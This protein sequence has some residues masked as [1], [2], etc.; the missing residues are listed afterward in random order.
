VTEAASAFGDLLREFR[1]RAGL[2]QSELA[3]KA[4][5]SEDAVGSLERGVR[6]APYRSTVALLGKALEL[7]AKESSEL[8]AARVAARARSACDVVTHNIR[9]ERTP[10]VGRESDVEHVLKLL[11]RSRL[12]SVTGS[13]GVGKTRVALETGRRLLK[14]SYPEVWFIDLGQLID[15]DFIAAKIAA[16]VRLSERNDTMTAL[17]SA[18]SKRHALLILDNCEH[19]L[20]QA[21]RAADAILESCPRVA[22]LATSREP[23]NVAGEFVYRLPSLLLEPA[24]ELFTQRAQAADPGYPVDEKSRALIKDLVQHLGGIPLVLELTAAQVPLLGLDVLRARKYEYLRVPSSR[25][26]LP[27]RQQTVLATIEWSYDL[28]TEPER[29][30]LRDVSIFVGGFTLAAAETVCS[31]AAV[32][33]SVVLPLLSALANKSLLTVEKVDDGVRY[34]LLEPVRGYAFEK[35]CETNGDDTIARRHAQWLATI[36]DE[37]ENDTVS[38]DR[39]AEM[40]PEF[41]NVRTAVAWSLN[42]EGPEDRALAGH[43]LTGLFGL[44]DR[45]GR[46]HEHRQWVETA[47]ARIDEERHPVV[48]AN[49]LR[50][51]MLRTQPER[52]ALDPVDHAVELCERSGDEVALARLLNVVAQVQT[53]HGMFSQ[54]EE[55]LRRAHDLMIRNRMENTRAY[56]SNLLA[57]SHLR[58]KEGR[59]DEARAEIAAAEAKALALGFKFIVVRIYYVRKAEIEYAAGNKRLALEIAQRMIDSE[60]GADP[61]VV[62][63]ALWRIP[64]LRMM[65]GDVEGAVEPLR[66]LLLLARSS[67][68]SFT[69]VEVE[70]AALGLALLGKPVIAARLLG[71]IQSQEQRAPF[72]RSALRQDAYDLLCS[73]LRQCLEEEAITGAVSAGKLLTPDEAI[74]EALA[75]LDVDSIP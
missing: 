12:V 17:A 68:G 51:R 53:T 4:N 41:D 67:Q 49:L 25:R 55:S 10:L 35:L 63:L 27:A 21:A 46:P 19:V 58:L 22:V 7:G 74:D 9:A 64:V 2:S 29:A 11:R 72:R 36:G 45:T 62:L 34:S 6:K 33:R 31:G 47:I 52:I 24:V 54:A 69:L 13:G 56:C 50:D 16:T 70:Y 42:A 61:S 57:R 18:L 5:I 59:L 14:G 28:L 73:T 8:E 1:V 3:E 23:L 71:R 15:G 39:V 48:A 20:D 38:P 44:W 26:D 66:E 32:D 75:A 37:A 43:I 60:F 40:L 30:L 65:L